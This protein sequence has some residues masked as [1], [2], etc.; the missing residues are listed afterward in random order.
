MQFKVLVVFRDAR[1]TMTGQANNSND[2]GRVFSPS[3]ILPPLFSVVMGS[4]PNVSMQNRFIPFG[5]LVILFRRITRASV[6]ATFKKTEK[7]ITNAIVYA[8]NFIHY[9]FYCFLVSFFVQECAHQN[10]LV[11]SACSM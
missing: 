4:L 7:K 1:V 5:A 3:T 9:P 10:P 2:Y 6:A 8:P 11:V